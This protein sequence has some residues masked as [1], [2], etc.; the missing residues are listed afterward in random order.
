MKSPIDPIENAKWQ[1][2]FKNLIFGFRQFGHGCGSAFGVHNSRVCSVANLKCPSRGRRNASGFTLVELLVVIAIVGI[3]IGLLLP[4]VQ[5]ARE[6]ARRITCCNRMKQI[7]L[8]VHNYESTFRM[9]PP[10]FL[11]NRDVQTRGSWSIHGRILPFIEQENLGDRIRLDVDWHKQVDSG[12]PATRINVYICPNEPNDFP[13]YRGGKPYVHPINYGFN[14]GSW[15]VYDPVSRRKGDGAF[16]TD[17]ATK[18]GHL[19]DGASHTLCAS[20]VK[21]YT[22]YIRNAVIDPGE[23]IPRDVGF[24]DGMGAELKLGPDVESNTGHSVWPDGRVHHSGFTTVFTPNTFVPYRHQ[25]KVY[26]VDFSSWQEGRSFSRTTYAAVTSRSYHPNLVNAVLMDGAVT[27]ISDAI[28]PFVFRGMG[29]A[30]GSEV[31]T[32][33]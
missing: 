31:F 8:A 13:R 7:G 27:S 28:D 21:A 22:P 33:P 26:D 6:A 11:L 12:V 32:L 19:L 18:F 10:A 15:R 16:Q 29:S 25:G 23:A 24:F 14:F 30:A 4:A 9:F 5:A 17:R 1:A 20:E 2:K 3:L